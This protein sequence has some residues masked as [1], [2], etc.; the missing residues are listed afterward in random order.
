MEE[1]V[2]VP[3]GGVT[4]DIWK[5]VDHNFTKSLVIESG[6][7]CQMEWPCCDMIIVFDYSPSI[8]TTEKIGKSNFSIIE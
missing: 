5:P 4:I 6:A 2:V 1:T 7:A 8:F 3:R